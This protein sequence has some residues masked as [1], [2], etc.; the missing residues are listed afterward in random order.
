[1]TTSPCIG[2]CRLDAA[3]SHCLG[4][5]RTAAEIAAWRDAPAPF[6]ERV[7]AD[8]P[9]RRARLGVGIHRLKWTR[10]DLMAFIAGTLEPGRPAGGTWAFGHFGGASEFRVGPGE[11]S[12][13]ER[14]G[15]ARLIARTP[16]AAARFDVP[17]QVR[18]MAPVASGDDPSRGPLVLAVPRNRQAPRA[19]LAYLGLDRDAVDP[20]DRDARLYDLG[21]GVPGAAF[22]LRTDDPELIRGLDDCLGLEWPD[23]FAGI[24][25]RIVEASPARVVLGPIG[26]VEAYGP[27]ESG[28]DDGPLAPIRLA[29][30][31]D[32]PNGLETPET[33]T[34]CA[35]YFP[36]RGTE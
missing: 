18:V 31:R 8:L 26:R 22:C 7:W 5:A 1:M 16:R 34:P 30:C 2:F 21:L 13:L 12:E 35:F 9:A 23:L 17:E 10:G 32:V 20:R 24:G 29:G 28:N 19:G 6:L 3:S 4:C 15:S 25:R 36:D 14:D 11:A 27:I 33:L